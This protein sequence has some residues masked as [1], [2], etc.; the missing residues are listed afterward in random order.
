MNDNEYNGMNGMMG[1]DEAA[2]MAATAGAMPIE[3][4]VLA[5]AYVPWQKFGRVF[6]EEDGFNTG[7]LFP[8]LDKPFTGKVNTR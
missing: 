8:D 5:M 3:G 4:A 1:M 7:T 6:S 2:N